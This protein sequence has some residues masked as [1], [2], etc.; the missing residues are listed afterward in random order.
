M[1]NN[2]AIEGIILFIL[3]VFL[4]GESFKLDNKGEW[5]LS[6]ALFP[7]IITI[8]ISI[9]SILLI[10]KSIRNAD[11]SNKKGKVK[12]VIGILLLSPIYLVLLPRVHFVPASIFY[13]GFFLFIMGER[14]L[15]LIILISVITPIAIQYVFGNLLNVYLP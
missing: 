6:P 11:T 14:K 15:K 8:A 10:I 2:E 9:F 5:A 3:S 7:L 1:K 13:L 12:Q 4:V